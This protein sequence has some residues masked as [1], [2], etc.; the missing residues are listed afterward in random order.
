MKQEEA[1]KTLKGAI[2]SFEEKYH[3]L[4]F[5]DIILNH[6]SFDSA[7]LLEHP[8]ACYNIHNT[9]SLTSAYMLDQAIADF[10]NSI[11]N[12]SCPD[13]T[14]TSLRTEDQL[15][16]LMDLI[17]N[18]VVGPLKL[19]EYFLMDE[20]SLTEKFKQ[21]L[22]ELAPN[23]K[24]SDSHD[25]ELDDL[26]NIFVDDR[27]VQISKVINENLQNLGVAP[28]GV[29]FSIDKVCEH[30]IK[31]PEK[32]SFDLLGQAIKKANELNLKRAR[33]YLE[34][35]FVNIRKVLDCRVKGN[36]HEITTTN[37]LVPPYFTNL[38]DGKTKAAHN[39]WMD[40]VDVLEDFVDS[41]KFYYLRR[42]INIWGDLIKL[43]Y[44]KSKHDSPYL[45]KRMKNYVVSMA[46]VFHG[47]RIGNAQCTS[48]HVGEYFIRKA[49]KANPSI[50]VI[51]EIGS[52]SRE[53]DAL[54]AKRIGI[55]AIVR[56]ALN[57]F[58]F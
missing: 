47:L 44:G 21:R 11:A 24:L 43:R 23:I 27:L 45:W 28:Y 4:F 42:T 31:E 48:I 3:A 26:Y 6:T 5:V 57:V 16:K 36:N 13:Y 52:G 17:R 2:K 18:K 12:K 38:K 46:K 19:E 39:G 25:E 40:G 33:A 37:P 8:D 32:S 56:E 14:E 10:S 35:A 50:Y 29:T 7:W 30:F 20:N 55:N 1:Y 49:R 34:E 53:V 15:E 58:Y 41:D 9:P 54:F 22:N 51:A